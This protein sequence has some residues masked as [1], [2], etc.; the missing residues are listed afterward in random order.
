MK[1][2][3]DITNFFIDLANSDKNN[4]YPMTNERLNML[5]YFAQDW[6]LARYNKPLFEEEIEAWD[7][8]EVRNYIERH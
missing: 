6:Y 7:D 4:K 2:A 1:K 5:L 8:S 3:K